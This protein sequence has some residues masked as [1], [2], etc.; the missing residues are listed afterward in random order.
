MI[1]PDETWKEITKQMLHKL[2]EITRIKLITY[3]M[4]SDIIGVIGTAFSCIDTFNW[5]KTDEGYEYWHKL[6]TPSLFTYQVEITEIQK[7]IQSL[8]TR[9]TYPEYYL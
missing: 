9:E 6:H 8:Y 1:Q 5:R 7:F 3:I 2:D 4:Q